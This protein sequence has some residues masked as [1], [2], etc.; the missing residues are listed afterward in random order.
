MPSTRHWCPPFRATVNPETGL[1]NVTEWLSPKRNGRRFARTLSSSVQGL[2]PGWWCWHWK[3]AV[4]GPRMRAQL[5]A[6][7]RAR[8]EPRL[9]QRRVEQAL[10]LKWCPIFFCVV[11][12]ALAASLL[13]FRGGRGAD[14]HVPQSHDVEREFCDACLSA[15][16]VQVVDC[17]T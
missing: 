1:Q 15:W 17:L 8:S 6:R 9:I 14:G 7:A 3:R 2:A 4:V 11:A 5:L 12:R 13:E 16:V 10:R